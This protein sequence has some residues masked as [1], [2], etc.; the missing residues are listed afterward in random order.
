MVLFHRLMS[1]FHAFI[2][3]GALLSDLKGGDGH[4]RGVRSETIDDCDLVPAGWAIILILDK[5]CTV[6]LHWPLLKFPFLNFHFLFNN[7]DHINNDIS[8][9]IIQGLGRLY[10][11]FDYHISQLFH[12]QIGILVTNIMH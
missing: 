3:K 12:Q 2:G 4:N 5:I 6:S 7:F 10:Y 11:L 1:N 9:G 8:S